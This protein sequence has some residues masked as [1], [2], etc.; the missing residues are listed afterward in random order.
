VRLLPE[1]MELLQAD[2]G[3][4]IGVTPLNQF[5]AMG[6]A[7]GSHANNSVAPSTKPGTKAAKSAAKPRRVKSAR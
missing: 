5:G 2:A 6:H 4:T 7:H 1:A 3:A